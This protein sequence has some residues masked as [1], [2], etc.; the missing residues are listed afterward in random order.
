MK[1]TGDAALGADGLG[2]GPGPRGQVTVLREDIR[3]LK[4]PPQRLG[5]SGREIHQSPW[6]YAAMVL[7]VFW[8]VA[9]LVY[10]KRQEKEKTH[11][12]LFRSRRAQRMARGRLKTAAKL[13]ASG[14]KDFYDEIAAA[15]YRYVGDK[16]GAS[17]SGLTS[18]SISALL[19]G[20]SVSEQLRA[21]FQQV[22]GACEEAR[23]T[24]GPR[25]RDEMEALRTRAEALLVGIERQ[26]S[27]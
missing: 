26:W 22:L 16:S 1:V 7:P 17:A 5:A 27:K 23:F 11:S 24:P 13:A 10:L 20:R 18:S 8:N 19:A 21:E 14:G 15:L 2:A 4:P 9:L 25:S 6:F 12:Q 3:S